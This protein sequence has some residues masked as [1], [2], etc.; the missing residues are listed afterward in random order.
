MKRIMFRIR[1]DTIDTMRSFSTLNELLDFI[2]FEKSQGKQYILTKK[3][4]NNPVL[5]QVDATS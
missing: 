4:G 5:T 2:V 1:S 3:T